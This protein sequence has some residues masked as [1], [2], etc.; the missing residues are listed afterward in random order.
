MK[1]VIVGAGEVGSHLA[2]MLASEGSEIT[3]IDNDAQRLA[4]V[5]TV[6][7]VATVQ[8]SPTSINVLREAGVGMA[9]LFV[10]VYPYTT[11]EVNI[12]S[13]ILAK[14][15]GAKKVTVR[16]NDEEYLNAE[17][18]VLFKE[19]GIELMFYPEKIAAD[20]IVDQ[21][22]HSAGSESLD[23]AHGKLQ[24]AVFRMEE[25]SPLMDMTLAEFA[26]MAQENDVQFR[27]IAI[28]RNERTI[29]PK[30]DTK[31]M[32]HDLVFTIA[33]R[34]G[35]APL[36]KYF[37]C[38]KVDIDKVMVYGG[39]EIGELLAKALH[40][41]MSVVKIIDKDKDRCIEM[42]ENLPESILVSNGDGRNP[43]FLIDESIKDYDAFVA[44]TES[45]ETNILSCVI[46]RKLGISRTV[47]E[48]ENIEYIH[49]AEEMGVDTVINKKLITAGRI[50]KF[51]LSG[52]AR[53]VKYMGGT[54]AEILEY[55]VTPGS[56][57]TRKPLKELNFPAN[58]II[59][60]VI[61]GSESMIA[62][63]DTHIEAYD[64]VAV[65]ALPESVAEV[66]KFFRA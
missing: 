17:N 30:F 54:D 61:R 59:G 60:G 9:D 65:F 7:D 38:R 37:G 45:D 43:D 18:K 28:T 64:R 1:I 66:D 34:E 39:S 55:T 47:A 3:V 4:K 62:V 6:A 21:L 15:L 19:M 16:I 57:I 32:Y 56:P 20:E 53:F 52:K 22:R 42:S 24:I 48:V 63:G 23:F 41:K 46:A 40:G 51:T 35:I 25:D 12:V 58:A 31:F 11:Q 14:N 27:A 33:K 36:M 44:V 13:A 10:S 29:I 26:A 5:L 50:F 49:L 2:K 8:G